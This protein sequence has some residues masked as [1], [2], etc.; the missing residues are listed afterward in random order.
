MSYGH[1]LKTQANDV[2]NAI[3]ANGLKPEDFAWDTG[4][5]LTL[6]H[7]P[8]DY[9]FT[10]EPYAF[11]WG[12][13]AHYSPGEVSADVHRQVPSWDGQLSLVENWLSNLKREIQAPDLWSLLSEQT[14]LVQ[15]ASLTRPNLHSAPLK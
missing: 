4:Q 8:S 14:A 6:R 10:F 2:L 1:L 7:T 11:E 3:L 5:T 15:A 12:H 9:F 13:Q